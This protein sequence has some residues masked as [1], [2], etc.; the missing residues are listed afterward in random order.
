M[1]LHLADCIVDLN[2]LCVVRD[3]VEESLTAT[4]AK[5]LR[6]LAQRPSVPVTKGD[7]LAE[8]WGYSRRSRSETVRTTINRLRPKIEQNSRAPAHLV[9][10]KGAGYCLILDEP[11]PSGPFVGRQEFL[12]E[13]IERIKEPGLTSIVGPPGVGK[14]RLVRELSVSL[15]GMARLVEVASCKTVVALSGTVAL[16][17]GLATDD[18]ASIGYALRERTLILDN[19]EQL[20]DLA[21]A[22]LAE[23]RLQAPSLAIV[24]TS[25]IPLAGHETLTL[26]PLSTEQTASLFRQH[27][28][29]SSD[30]AMRI[31]ATLGGLP[32]AAEI[33][34]ACLAFLE[35]DALARE[36]ANPA[37][38][39]DIPG[40][41]DG[42]LSAALAS[43]WRLLSAEDQRSLSA[44]SLF[45]GDIPL[46]GMRALTGSSPLALTARL[47]AL[48]WIRRT[49]AG[50][51]LLPPIRSWLLRYRPPTARV[52]AAYL[53][54]VE[55]AGEGVGTADQRHAVRELLSENPQ[56]AV[57]IALAASP[58][59]G[60]EGQERVDL[61]LLEECQVVALPDELRVE[62]LTTYAETARRNGLNLKT[63]EA[64]EAALELA[65]DQQRPRALL[66]LGSAQRHLA[67]SGAAE[68]L[69]AASR[70]DCK[71]AA[72]A[73]RQLAILHG[74]HGRLHEEAS[75]L[76]RARVLCEQSGAVGALG[77]VLLSEGR[78]HMRSRRLPES[79]AS[80]RSALSSH[81]RPMGRAIAQLGLAAAL[82]ETSQT[83]EALALLEDAIAFFSSKALREH[84][85]AAR[86]H[87]A[88]AH[89]TARD[90]K[91]SLAELTRAM[92]VARTL[93]LPRHVAAILNQFAVT[94]TQI[95]DSSSAL[96]HA[97]AAHAAFAALGERHNLA[98]AEEVLGRAQHQAGDLDAA[99]ATYRSSAHRYEQSGI[100]HG[101]AIDVRGWLALCLAEAGDV[102]EAR[103]VLPTADEAA[104]HGSS[105]RAAL[106]L[107]A[108]T[109]PAALERIR[110]GD[111]PESDL[112]VRLI[113]R[114]GSR[115][116]G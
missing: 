88:E 54:W 109:D 63:I 84:E 32:L 4:E 94:Y 51:V 87:I 59:H 9:T 65:A 85:A 103:R 19:L 35:P 37:E 104:G 2:K 29:V 113:S 62:L 45:Q 73:L 43:S 10:V 95:G 74:F 53:S 86:L 101:G 48:A 89:L 38:V 110:S 70:G 69:A 44:L 105:E 102:D 64:A 25:R 96:R 71:V 112:A 108:L 83:D 68:T 40:G 7:L 26:E 23:L 21:P 55:A 66:A 27:A 116:L 76:E 52:R 80:Y 93:E 90:P 33:A 14:S 5:L 1:V 78:H 72:E 115:Q 15:K 57:S 34:A 58:R 16:T 36:L 6:H 100:L 47:H 60:G 81:R 18:L 98:V 3:G 61:E 75:C 31:V 56:R 22:W 79:Q 111:D 67:L 114:A 92:A 12:A 8:V 13:L 107:A 49:P 91:A 50:V 30:D 28:E 82:I 41:R 20:A 11:E 106:F 46:T 39:L 97:H 99:A 77:P 17:L 42:S 24:T